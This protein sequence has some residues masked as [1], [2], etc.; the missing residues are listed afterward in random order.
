MNIQPGGSHIMVC[1]DWH[2]NTNW[3]IACT[4]IA[5]DARVDTIIQVGDFGVWPGEGGVNYLDDLDTAA[6]MNGL[7]I[8][9]LDGNHEDH[10][11]LDELVATATSTEEGFYPIR[12]NIFFSPRA[13]KWEWDGRTFMTVGGAYSIDRR[14]RKLDKSWWAQEELTIP[15]AERAMAQGKVDYLFTHDAPFNIPMN[16]Y[17]AGKDGFSSSFQRQL[18]DKVGAASRPTRWFHGHYHR[19]MTYGFPLYDPYTE[20]HA[21]DM[22]GTGPSNFVFLD[23]MIDTIS[24][25]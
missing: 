6:K 20:V 15:Q 3:A 22:D 18:M 12:E 1:G 7:K 14:F 11:Q 16:L 23:T 9:F 13:N 19:R 21:L 5:H 25:H 24:S 2:G 17:L 8:I 10:N 4:G